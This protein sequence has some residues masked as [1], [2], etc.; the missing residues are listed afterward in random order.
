ML[1]EEILD[2]LFDMTF[3]SLEEIRL[4]TVVERIILG[5][6]KND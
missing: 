6:L 1:I 5:A 4:Q 3:K 2:Q